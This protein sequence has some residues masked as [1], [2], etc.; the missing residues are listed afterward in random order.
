MNEDNWE[1][2]YR[3][4]FAR[5]DDDKG[6]TIEGRIE[7]E[8]Q[9]AYLVNWTNGGQ[10]WLPKSCILESDINGN[11]ITTTVKTWWARRNGHA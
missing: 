10:T 11:L 6:V 7:H 2:D 8:T 4:S 9:K 5:E 1:R 3:P